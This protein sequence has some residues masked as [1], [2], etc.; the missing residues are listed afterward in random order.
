VLA[1][2]LVLVL[3]QALVQ[4]LALALALVLVQEP[5]QPKEAALVSFV[6]YKNP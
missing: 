4:A 1:L 5:Q 3:V 6:M 2:V